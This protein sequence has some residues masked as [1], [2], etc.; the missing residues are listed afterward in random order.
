[1]ALKKWPAPHLRPKIV[2]CIHDE[3]AVECNESQ[4]DEVRALLV[5]CMSNKE[6]FRKF[7]AEGRFLEVEIGAEEKIG[8]NYKGDKK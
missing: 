6:N 3:I 5:D 7:V 4:K 8:I 1:M 2:N